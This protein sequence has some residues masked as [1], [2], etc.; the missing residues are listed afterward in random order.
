VKISYSGNYDSVF[1]NIF[2][3]AYK[4]K[5]V[6]FIDSNLYIYVNA[7]FDEKVVLHKLFRRQKEKNYWKK[8]FINHKFY[9]IEEHY[10]LDVD[11]NYLQKSSSQRSDFYECV[12]KAVNTNAVQNNSKIY[13]VIRTQFI[14]ENTIAR[15]LDSIDVL[16]R[17][18][19]NFQIEVVFSVNN[20]IEAQEIIKTKLSEIKN[21]YEFNINTYFV[22]KEKYYPRVSA[23]IN[24]VLNMDDEAF[25]W[26]IDDDDFA[27]PQTFDELNFYLNKKS[28]L[29]ANSVV[30]EEIWNNNSKN[31][32][33][34]RSKYLK[35]YDGSKYTDII[36]GNNGIP[37]CSVIY[38]VSV[39]KKV[40]SKYN[41]YGDYN[42]D[43]TVLLLAIRETDFVMQLPVSIAGISYH[44]KNTILEKDR[45]YWQ[46]SYVTFMREVVNSGLARNLFTEHIERD[47][48]NTRKKINIGSKLI[49]VL[50]KKGFINFIKFAFLFI[51][52]GRK[53]FKDGIDTI[54]M[55]E[56]EKQTKK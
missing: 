39:L 20:I 11:Y 41:L 14:R 2:V 34:D 9:G 19:N 53:Y 13:I 29:I 6:S 22:K 42:E 45:S 25:V 36:S 56:S 1:F 55:M 37:V 24:P 54:E 35:T 31:N 7:K 15:L 43:Y 44:G 23:M 3:E 38:P 8:N 28:V 50:R 16:Y 47:R 33:P 12:R 27:F 49:Y 46:K 52:K 4:K 17:S 26:Y 51:T 40:F 30:F 5:L 10:D 18:V 32:Y 48:K 21:N